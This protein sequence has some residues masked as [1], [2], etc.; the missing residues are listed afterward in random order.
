M[1]KLD[2]RSLLQNIGDKFSNVDNPNSLSN[3]FW[4]SKAGSNLVGWQEFFN[5]PKS[6]IKI[7]PDFQ[8]KIGD[9]EFKST[10]KVAGNVIK[11]G[12]EE[13][14]TQVPKVFSDVGKVIH[15]VATGN[16]NDVT[17]TS[18]PAIFGE[19]IMTYFVR[20]DKGNVIRK[21]F[22]NVGYKGPGKWTV[23]FTN[24]RFPEFNITESSAY[25]TASKAL[26]AA[27]MPLAAY[28]L[29]NPIGM[30]KML[31]FNSALG[32]LINSATSGFEEGSFDKGFW[33]TAYGTAPDLAKSYGLLKATDKFTR[34]G[35]LPVK[36]TANVLQGIMYD[37]VSGNETNGASILIDA[38]FPVAEDLSSKAFSSLDEAVRTIQGK[39]IDKIGKGVRK[40][41]G[42]YTDLKRFVEQTRPYK[43]RTKGKNNMFG[44]FMGFEIYEDED[45]KIRVKFNS[46]KAALGILILGGF[47]LKSEDLDDLEGIMEAEKYKG[48]D[49][50]NPNGVET[51][52]S[53]KNDIYKSLE[54]VK[55]STGK[56]VDIS[57]KSY[58]DLDREVETSKFKERLGIQKTQGENIAEEWKNKL[59]ELKQSRTPQDSA[60]VRKELEELDKIRKRNEI[61]R[62]R[63]EKARKYSKI[64][65]DYKARADRAYAD[66]NKKLGD[67]Y[68]QKYID[69]KNTADI[70]YKWS[71]KF[72]NESPEQIRNEIP[73]KEKIDVNKIPDEQKQQEVYGTAGI[74]SNVKEEASKTFS[75]IQGR[76]ILVNSLKEFERSNINTKVL[77]YVLQNKYNIETIVD[78]IEG[79]KSYSPE[80]ESLVSKLRNDFKEI[81]EAE[82]KSGIAPDI[83]SNEEYVSH[84]S[85]AQV[86]ASNLSRK[87]LNTKFGTRSQTLMEIYN[88]LKARTNKDW[89]GDADIWDR[90]NE[91]FARA[92]EGIINQTIK[93]DPNKSYLEQIQEGVKP[94]DRIPFD[95][96]IGIG[97]KLFKKNTWI[98]RL[99][100][101]E[102]E[103]SIE[104]WRD[105]G[106]DIF[107]MVQDLKYAMVERGPYISKTVDVYKSNPQDPLPFILKM[108]EDL[109]FKQGTK[110]FSDFYGD[111]AKKFNRTK[112][113][114]ARER[115]A[116]G[117]ANEVAN[118]RLNKQI[119]RVENWAR[120]VDIKDGITRDFVDRELMN[121]FT[122]GS[123]TMYQLEEF[124]DYTRRYIQTSNIGG[125]ITITMM[126]PLEVLR[127][128]PRYGPNKTIEA[129]YDTLFNKDAINYRFIKDYSN[130]MQY[131][132][133]DGTK[134]EKSKVDK[135]LQGLEKSGYFG[136]SKLEDWKNEVYLRAA[137]LEGIEKGLE[138]DELGRFVMDE[139][140]K[141]SLNFSNTS[142]PALLRNPFM[143]FFSMYST[144]PTKQLGLM[145]RS[146]EDALVSKEGFK[147]KDAQFLVGMLFSTWVTKK[148]FGWM[149]GNEEDD[150]F[151]DYGYFDMLL[152]SPPQGYNPLFDT[153]KSYGEFNEAKRTS[154][155]GEYDYEKAKQTL[156]RN[157]NKTIVPYGNQ[158]LNTTFAT[159]GDISR[160]YAETP[161]GNVKYPA[162]SKPM[163]IVKSVLFSRY[164]N[165][166]A[167][168]YFNGVEKGINMALTE[169][170]SE[171]YKQE[172]LNGGNPRRIY[173]MFI[174]KKIETKEEN[175]I[176]KNVKST[177]EDVISNGKIY[178]WNDEKQDSDY[179]EINK[180]LSVPKLTNNKELNDEILI[181][182]N[183]KLTSRKNDI[184]KLYYKGYITEDIAVSKITQID[185]I[186]EWISEMTKEQ[187]ISKPSFKKG[188]NID[189]PKVAS[190]NG[191]KTN[192]RN[193][194][195]KKISIKTEISKIPNLE[196]LSELVLD[197]VE[198]MKKF[199]DKRL[200]EID[201]N[202]KSSYKFEPLEGI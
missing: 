109:G 21:P 149:F 126:Q 93:L 104:G 91:R 173:D 83:A 131:M 32:G 124:V 56:K 86:Y 159:I 139:F 64:A 36:S 37:E 52:Q 99:I 199:V 158:L 25:S 45:G 189:I 44:A 100:T 13:I 179:V 78:Y 80:L 6:Q 144:Y 119:V 101:S 176:L 79:R 115:L 160:G 136:T 138:G 3:K 193:I 4:N 188:G 31:G 9:T 98:Q 1:P 123:K 110:E 111:V 2:F 129:I 68:Y 48:M 87:L 92:S 15:G 145:L 163:D 167:K 18:K 28:G 133:T 60:R 169:K 73:I 43:H 146:M 29:S 135:A 142:V 168:N 186:K 191:V 151:A 162:P 62:K 34:V 8:P 132:T 125:K 153:I 114:E 61:S 154:S 201:N 112:D 77:S 23:P 150:L 182:Y 35:K 85:D 187:K 172:L 128:I 57:N 19:D 40:S 42:T 27:G 54:K 63:T 157:L 130:I 120:N 10:A 116:W 147:S 106:P 105:L 20:D 148:A 14:A 171:F 102:L 50:D 127:A 140:E 103:N 177:K 121:I 118:A 65:M 70:E 156:T 184:M 88:P 185:M 97:Q 38:M 90:L 108:T 67:K 33:G 152:G 55:K 183:S 16:T 58:D 46:K 41:D 180:D 194:P 170:E 7:G 117:I 155:P 161:T 196:P 197:S 51:P 178:F 200:S 143:K 96:K 59:N 122:N 107:N 137:E 95:K 26:D 198:G 69:A 165:E 94:E 76:T 141:Y 49:L 66:G 134:I 202:I 22:D 89:I 166:E 47:P 195:S 71:E 75:N 192:I 113:P 24:V 81:R 30:L 164:S 174:N 175:K 5:D 17:L 11:S 84:L 12:V 72:E 74:L 190:I 53:I 39:I 82:I 181:D